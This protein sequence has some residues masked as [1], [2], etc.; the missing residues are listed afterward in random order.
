V[1]CNRLKVIINLSHRNNPKNILICYVLLV[2]DL[3]KMEHEIDAKF[4]G[5]IVNEYNHYFFAVSGLL[6]CF[7]QVNTIK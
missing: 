1:A 3:A 7:T 5:N 2:Y 6:L 4:V